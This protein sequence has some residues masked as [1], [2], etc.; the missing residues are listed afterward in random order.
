VLIHGHGQYLP[1]RALLDSGSQSNFISELR[2]QKL[3]LSRKRTS[4]RTQGININLSSH[5]CVDIHMKSRHSDWH[6]T[7]NCAI[8]PRIT[9]LTPTMRFDTNSWNLPNDINLADELF[10]EPGPIDILIGADTFYEIV[11]K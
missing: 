2:V 3:Q 5:H 1:F 8:L 11:T 9:G 7:L 6:S 4:V 10:Y